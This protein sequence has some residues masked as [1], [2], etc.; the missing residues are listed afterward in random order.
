MELARVLCLC[1]QHSHACT[2]PSLLS[3]VITRYIGRSF[4]CTTNTYKSRQNT[5][6]YIIMNPNGY[7]ALSPPP[8]SCRTRMV[9]K[10]SGY[11]DFHSIFADVISIQVKVNERKK[12]ILSI[13]IQKPKI[14]STFDISL[15]YKKRSK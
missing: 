5:N 6:K 10:R 9:T 3:I 13:S 7:S 11:R 2:P 8:P 1:C 14:H 15:G 4:P 12:K